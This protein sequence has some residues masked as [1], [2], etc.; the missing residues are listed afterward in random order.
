MQTLWG[1]TESFRG[2]N[3]FKMEGVFEASKSKKENE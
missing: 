1:L 3:N 2:E